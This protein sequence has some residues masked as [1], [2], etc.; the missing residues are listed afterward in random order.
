MIPNQSYSLIRTIANQIYACKCEWHLGNRKGWDGWEEN[1]RAGVQYIL[2]TAVM[3]LAT[4]PHR[5]YSHNLYTV[6]HFFMPRVKK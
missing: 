6:G 1:Q 5:R 4:H 2:H 3:E